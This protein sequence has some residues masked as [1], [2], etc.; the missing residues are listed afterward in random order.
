MTD[1]TIEPR[2]RAT[3][4]PIESRDVPQVGAFLYEQFR[5]QPAIDQISAHD[6]A[7]NIRAPWAASGERHGVLLRD[8]EQIVGVYVAYHSPPRTTASGSHRFCNLADWAVD[9]AFRAQSLPLAM[10]LIR[11][12]GFIQ[13]DFTARD[14]VARMNSRL[15]FREIR[16]HPYLA[17]NNPFSWRAGARILTRHSDIAAVLTGDDA[18][19]YEDHRGI[20]GLRQIAAVVGHRACH[21]AYRRRRVPLRMLGGRTLPVACVLHVS[22]KDVYRHARSAIA[23]HLSRRGMPLIWSEVHVAGIQPPGARHSEVFASPRMYRGDAVAP[24]EIDYL[25]SELMFG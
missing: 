22:D 17:V 10:T 7:Q 15:G 1:E 4:E 5:G 19:H 16:T 18:R 12:K 11:Q 23:R 20:T 14:E 8:G 6:W 3:I 13:T 24:D 2:H 21:I 25:Y 9:D